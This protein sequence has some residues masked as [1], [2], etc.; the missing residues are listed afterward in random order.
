MTARKHRARDR[1]ER[2]CLS[3]LD[4]RP[5]RAEI[6]AELKRVMDFD[7]YVWLLTDPVTTV[8]SAPLADVPC[9][10]QLPA[11]I[12]LKYLTTVNRWTSLAQ[13][14]VPVGLLQH[15]TGG[16][17]HLSLVWR[18]LL[19]DFGVRDIASVVLADS[20]GCWGFLDLWTR[21]GKSFGTADADLLTDIAGPVCTALRRRQATA[22][23][24]AT[25]E[26]DIDDGP[27]VMILDDGLRICSRTTA[28]T[29][30]LRS[31]LPTAADRAPIPA[32]ALNVAAQLLAV[33]A[34]VDDHPAAARTFVRGHTWVSLRASRLE[35]P[36][37]PGTIA[38]SIEQTPAGPR[39]DLFARSHGLSPREQE[40]LVKLARGAD[41]AEI[42]ERMSIS[43]Y[44]VQDHLKSIFAK[45]A[46]TGRGAVIT[47]ALG[48]GYG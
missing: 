42:A 48:P 10:P 26:P 47:A 34:G 29:K 27:A 1:I 12:R 20:Y 21:G 35:A 17:L 23:A 33:E 24:I 28:T 16:Q 31:L 39:L 37:E 11:L 32:A 13:G 2:L 30:W 8:G 14:R 4:E 38:V 41:T 7:A 43:E 15:N 18:E 45:T 25:T 6:L 19:Q 22:F 46:L 3:T 44:T 5:L 9:L 36:S 40:L